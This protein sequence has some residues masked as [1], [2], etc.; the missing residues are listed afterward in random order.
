MGEE[1]LVVAETIP[2]D[3]TLLGNIKCS[4]IKLLKSCYDES[5]T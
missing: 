5:P 1:C 4:I 3:L 2:F